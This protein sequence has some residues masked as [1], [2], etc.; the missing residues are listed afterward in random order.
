MTGRGGLAEKGTGPEKKCGEENGC[1][2]AGE[3]AAFRDYYH[4]LDRCCC[5]CMYTT[6]GLA[7]KVA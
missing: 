3:Q 7:A 1:L 4:L 6:A 2:V 5:V